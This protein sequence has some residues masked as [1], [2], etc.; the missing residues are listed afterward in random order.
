MSTV[1]RKLSAFVLVSVAA[2]LFGGLA[3]A[4]PGITD[5][6][7]R[8]GMWTPLSGPV[9]LLGQ[10][11]R[12]GVRLWVKEINDKGGIHGRKINFIAYDDAGSPQEA[13]PRSGD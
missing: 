2:A 7:I 3:R 8:I 5:N 9:A 4:E 1:T 12:D 11:A 13:R 6:E 10:S